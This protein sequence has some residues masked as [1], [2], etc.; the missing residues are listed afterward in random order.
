LTKLVKLGEMRNLL[1]FE[2]KQ[3]LLYSAPF[4]PR[5]WVTSQDPYSLRKCRWRDRKPCWSK[6]ICVC[7]CCLQY[8]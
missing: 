6:N 8:L 1:G 7:Q 5:K 2:Y 4:L 3:L